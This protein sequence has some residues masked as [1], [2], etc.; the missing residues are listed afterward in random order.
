M[1]VVKVTKRLIGAIGALIVSVVLC[2]GVCLAWFA[3]NDDVNGN[4]LSSSVHDEDISEFVVSAY[5]LTKNADGTYAIGAKSSGSL[6][7]MAAYGG[8]L[9]GSETTTALLLH[10]TYVTK[11]PNK[12]FRVQANC[13]KEYSLTPKEDENDT[14]QCYLSDAV[15]IFKD[16]T[17]TK[18]GTEVAGG[19]LE[20]NA[21]GEKFA[22]EETVNGE[23]VTNKY[24]IPIAE[25]LKSDSGSG[26]VFCVIDYS[27]DNI[28]ALYAI[29]AENGGGISSQIKFS[30]GATDGATDIVFFIEES[31]S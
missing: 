24:D 29:A 22:K 15:E 6:V 14:F 26:E 20:I 2:I 1:K 31:R 3:S 13:N 25:D 30:F 23:K 19:T 9:I 27:E 21:A 11:N 8:G 17:V 4:G 5:S 16:V 18:S 12:T 10:I 7:E 28:T